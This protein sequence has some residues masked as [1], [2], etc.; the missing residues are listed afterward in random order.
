M[1]FCSSALLFDICP[2]AVHLQ[3][4]LMSTHVLFHYASLSVRL[5][6]LLRSESLQLSSQE[7]FMQVLQQDGDMLQIILRSLQV[8]SKPQANMHLLQVLDQQ[9]FCTQCCLKL[10]THLHNIPT[11]AHAKS[12]AYLLLAL[13]TCTFTDMLRMYGWKVCSSILSVFH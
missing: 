12:T 2:V 4:L 3:Q 10:G 6:S 8:C 7:L 1:N 13:C 11:C 5:C 9:R